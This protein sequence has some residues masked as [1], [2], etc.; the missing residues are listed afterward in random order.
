MRLREFF[1]TT[2]VMI[3]AFN[4]PTAWP[5]LRF[6]AAHDL[7]ETDEARPDAS[8]PA[9]PSA[10][11]M[12]DRAL[13][14]AYQ[15]TL[16]ILRTPGPCSNFFGGPAIAVEVFNGFMAAV[17]KDYFVRGIGMRMSGSVTTVVNAASNRQ[18][19]L[20]E[21]VSIN[22]NGPFYGRKTVTTSPLL[23]RVGSFEANSPEVR[24]LMLLHELGHLIKG[25]DG[26]WLLPDDGHDESLSRQNSQKIEAL[27]GALIKD[28]GTQQDSINLVTKKKASQKTVALNTTT[29]T[30]R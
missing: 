26:N 18:Y 20:F 11:I 27:C 21:K 16:S 29:R 4:T 25:P 12:K 28:L 3:F 2:L 1:V 15:N 22:M 30:P 6:T 19:R 14:S 23:S 9:A 13:G 8:M 10:G 17:T 24:V 7:A 5:R